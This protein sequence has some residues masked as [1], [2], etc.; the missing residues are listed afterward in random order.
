MDAFVKLLTADSS[1]FG[2]TVHNWIL[3]VGAIVVLWGIV[4]AKDF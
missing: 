4:L 1:I 2:Y 3:L